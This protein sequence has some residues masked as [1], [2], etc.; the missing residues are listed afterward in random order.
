MSGQPTKAE[1][2]S[3]Q[4]PGELAQLDSAI[5]DG[6]EAGIS[7]LQRL[8]RQKSI[9]ATGDGVRDCAE[10]TAELLGD[11]GADV[12]L[13][14][15]GPSGF[16]LVYGRLDRFPS[17]HHN[18]P[19]LLLYCLYDVQPAEPSEWSLPPFAAERTVDGRI[20]ARGAC[21]TKGPLV[22]FIEAVRAMRKSNQPLPPIHF[23]VEGEEEI[24]SPNLSGGLR[25]I[26]EELSSTSVMFLPGV[27]PVEI[28]SSLE[29]ML[30]FKGML[31][32]EIEA[33]VRDHDVHS[34]TAP[35]L[36]NAA[37]RL[38]MLLANVAA[39]RD[40]IVKPDVPEDPESAREL[41]VS[42]REVA[43][44]FD[45]DAFL[46]LYG[47]PRG[48][49]M[50]SPSREDLVM[51]YLLSPTFNISG[52]RSGYTGVGPKTINPATATAKLDIRLL[53]GM[54]ST[55]TLAR[56]REA[57]DRIAGDVAR[58][59]HIHSYNAS[60]T[61][62]TGRMTS[63]IQQAAALIGKQAVVF[64]IAPGSAPWSVITDSLGHSLDHVWQT[65]REAQA[66]AHAIDEF[67][68]VEEFEATARLHAVILQSLGRIL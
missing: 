14:E 8:L 10:L 23:V 30:G 66:R 54:D 3:R 18:P 61:R 40:E 29:I 42:A 67:I 4:A 45:P 19:H 48:F 52:L 53:P 41:E 27:C 26:R 37:W 9:S 49:L 28:G 16:P 68:S 60:R 46:R 35:I 24:G 17:G 36:D 58:V 5:E 21:N 63:A 38:V 34:R 32:V 1:D 57:V 56:L 12:R 33:R 59:D 51:Q 55:K 47:N 22:A 62:R 65:C 11:L 31:Y 6:L 15:T 43:G 50:G 2:L 44:A 20:V 39:M 64:P 25:T 13:V 7:R